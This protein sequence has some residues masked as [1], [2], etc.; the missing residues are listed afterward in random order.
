MTNVPEE[1]EITM[2]FVQPSARRRA[3][4][5]LAF[6]LLLR[7][8]GA[9]AAA[10]A[11]TEMGEASAAFAEAERRA[12][13]DPAGAVAIYERGLAALPDAPG[14]APARAAVVLAIV[15]AHASAFAGDGDIARLYRAR[16]LLDRY[17]GPLDLLDEEGRSAAEERRVG[18]LDQIAAV[19]ARMRAEALAREAEAARRRGRALTV[20]GLAMATGAALGFGV[21]GLGIARGRATDR[22][23]D[24]LRREK[25]WETPCA[26][27]D[28]A[29][30]DERGAALDPLVAR[31]SRANGMV[32]GG[33]LIGGALACAAIALIIGGRKGIRR[34]AEIEA[35]PSVRGPG[36]GLG[37]G[38]TVRGRF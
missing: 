28:A 6:A 35:T 12:A 15:D 23:L 2:R 4:V 31:G 36:L 18:L 27:G 19:E 25:G 17:L 11:P 24:A 22:E 8:P 7:L 33:A 21:T 1:L 14:Y 20:G 3:A 9:S 37:L 34:A 30:V 26:A 10:A 5:G 13:R 29:C 16:E 32:L 38:V